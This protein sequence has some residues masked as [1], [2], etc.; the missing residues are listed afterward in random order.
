MCE[1]LIRFTLIVRDGCH[2]CDD[3]R[4]AL[5]AFAAEL[6]VTWTECDVDGDEALRQRFHTLVPVL[7]LGEQVVCHHFLDSVAL[8]AA[9]DR[10]RGGLR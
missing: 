10:A 4:D 1:E 9:V 6:G 8:R 7:M 3:M 5:A 2:L